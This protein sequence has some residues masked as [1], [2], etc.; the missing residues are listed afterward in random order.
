MTEWTIETLK[1]HF[2]DLLAER[3]NTI[4][5][6]DKAFTEAIEKIETRLNEIPQNYAQNAEYNTLRSEIET[7]KADHVQRR[8]F[9]EIKDQYSQGRGA[10]LAAAAAM[11]VIITLIT[12]AL[13]LMYSNQITHA[14]I[15]NQ[16][17]RESP[18][19]EDKT[20]IEDEIHQLQQE[21]VLLKTQLATHEA[22]DKFRYAQHN[23]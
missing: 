22:T 14:D 20:Q 3:I 11:G 13:G 5:Q 15:S 19:A 23:K 16:I 7:I 18:W 4:R 6:T 12:V 9:N 21:V 1:A 8:E 10:R 2:D 17:A